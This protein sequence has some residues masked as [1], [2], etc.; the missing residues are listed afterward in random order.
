MLQL[1]GQ[2]KLA[3]AL[4]SLEDLPGAWMRVMDVEREREREGGGQRGGNPAQFDYD[5]E[6]KI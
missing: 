5:V 1:A 6:T 2:E 4:C 3:L